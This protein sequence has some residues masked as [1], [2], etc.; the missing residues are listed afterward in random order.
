MRRLT[1]SS[2]LALLL[3]TCAT[4][5]AQDWR[6]VP[7]SAATDGVRDNLGH[8]LTHGEDGE[9]VGA[10]AALTVTVVLPPSP[11]A[12]LLTFARY[13]QRSPAN[14]RARSHWAASLRA[15]GGQ[16][17][18]LQRSGVTRGGLERVVVPA[19]RTQVEVRLR[20]KM[21]R[22]ARLT[23]FG[24]YELRAGQGDVWLALGA[25]IQESAFDHGRFKREVRERYGADP[26]V[27][28]RAIS[29]WASGHLADA[30]PKLLAAYPE[31]RYVAVHI[32][33]NNVTRARPFPGGAS[34]LRADL[35]AIIDTIRAA[36]KEPILARLSYRAYKSRPS[37]GPARLG[38]LPYVEALYDP[39]IAHAMPRFYDHGARRG[40]VDPYGW[41]QEHRDELGRDGVHLNAAGQHS[42]VRLWVEGAAAVVYGL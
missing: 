19:R 34:R 23:W 6:L 22:R 26:V 27:L 18:T 32:G 5:A 11:H 10:D 7:L 15:P 21:A 31:A 24:L 39:L 42:W 29:G 38:S 41:F 35:I 40:R 25:S 9:I 13:E 1:E 28:N 2:L 4:A 17:A 8:A 30:L 16:W 33:G 3:F 14:E 12:A 37:V 36:G 20:V